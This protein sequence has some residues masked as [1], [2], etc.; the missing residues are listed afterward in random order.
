[1]QLMKVTCCVMNTQT[2]DGYLLI[3]HEG[4][5]R[6]RNTTMSRL[7][8]ESVEKLPSRKEWQDGQVVGKSYAKVN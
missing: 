8:A 5:K 6:D 1:M 7:M 3:F 2:V 4:P